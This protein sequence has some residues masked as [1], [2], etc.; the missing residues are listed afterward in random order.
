MYGRT[1]AGSEKILGPEHTST[2]R[3]VNN[4]GNLYVGQGRLAEAEAMYERALAGREK[5]LG[6]EHMSTVDSAQ[7]LSALRNSGRES[8]SDDEPAGYKPAL[9]EH[10]K[11]R[12]SHDV[13]LRSFS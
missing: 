10:P 6:P 12:L 9:P 3:T 1:L 13:T 5:A 2:L 8:A 7:R 11:S 4:L